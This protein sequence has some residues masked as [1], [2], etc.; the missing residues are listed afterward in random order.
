MPPLNMNNP[1]VFPFQPSLVV[2]LWDAFTGANTLAGDVTVKIGQTSPLFQKQSQAAFVFASLGNGNVTVSVRST[3]D[4][5]YYLPVD[6]PLTLPFERPP[7]T[8]WPQPPVWQGYPDITLADPSKMLDDPEQTPAYLAQRTLTTLLPTTS[9]PF[10]AGAT[11]VRGVVKNAGTPLSGAL[12][13]TASLAQPGQFPV[14]VISPGGQT[15]AAVN[16]AVVNTPVIDSV[17]PATVIAGA[18]AFELSIAGSGF[19]PGAVVKLNGTALTTAFITANALFAQV[20]GAEVATAAQLSVAVSNPDGTASNQQTLTVAAAPAI[21]SAAGSIDPPTVTAGS[22]AFTLTVQGSGFATD[23]AVELSG[24]ALATTFVSSTE[25]Q[26]QIAPAQ[27]AASAQLNVVVVNPG[28]PALTSN[29]EVL[30][31]VSTPVINSLE[32]GAVIAGSG[33]ITLTIGGSGFVAGSVAEVGG[34][35]IPTVFMNATEITAQVTAAQVASVGQLS[36]LVSNPGGASSNAQTLTVAAAPTIRSIAPATVAA[37]SAAFELTVLGSG[38]ASG[39]VVNLNGNALPTT[40]VSSVELDAIVPR[41]GYT[42]GSDGT[43]VLFFDDISGR[44]Q[45]VT[46]IVTH[47]SVPNPKLVNVT[48]LRGATVSVDIDMSS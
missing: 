44:S 35:A 2:L 8:L 15:S 1:D 40:F 28:P 23:A 41:S 30:A 20:T 11:L 9:Y 10:P 13:T 19:E 42:T 46:L 39:A 47:P 43:F 4:E 7:A 36:I 16:L 24:A 21:S 14:V 22:A 17:N 6:I 12:V 27:V 48:V 37:D 26:A 29:A 5:P 32:P 3:P 31:V 18:A 45:P 38:F 34:T 25:V 33:P